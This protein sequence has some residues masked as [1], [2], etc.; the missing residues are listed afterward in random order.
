MSGIRVGGSASLFGVPVAPADSLTPAE[1][2]Y[3][4]DVR[5]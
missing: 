3:L 1:V 2:L 5:L 4:G